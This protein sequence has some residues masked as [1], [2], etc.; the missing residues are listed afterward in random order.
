MIYT[1]G[2]YLKA[3][4]RLTFEECFVIHNHIIESADVNDREFKEFW[5]EMMLAA[6]AY[7]NIRAKWSVQ[8]FTE[9]READARRT[10]QHN[11]FMASLKL[12]YSYMK[13][14]KWNTDWFEK[15]GTTE[16]DRKRFGDFACYLV[17]VSSLN[18]R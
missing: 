3:N 9:Q 12:I 8:T 1:Y 15:L 2:E 11:A 14:Q 6:I 17:Y 13:E 18:T 5:N 10:R 4:D 16:N 7:A